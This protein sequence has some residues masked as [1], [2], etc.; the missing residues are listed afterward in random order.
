LEIASSSEG[1]PGGSRLRRADL[2]V[3]VAVAALA[4]VLCLWSV[5]AAGG[6]LFS[7]LPEG[8]YP[9][10][11]AGFRAG[12]LYV[13]LDPPAELQALADP[14]DPTANAPYRAH[15]M[16]YYHGRYFLY[17]GVTPVVLFFWP[18]AAATGWYPTDSCAAVAFSF[19]SVVAG[20]ALLLAVRRRHFP[21]APLWLLAL[22]AS[23][24]ALESSILTLTARA[25]FYQVPIAAAAALGLL[26][27]GAIFRALHS[28][29]RGAAWLAAASLLLGLSVGARPTYLPSGLALVVAGAWLIGPESRWRPRLQLALAALLPALACGLGIAAYNWLRFGSITEF[30]MRYQLAGTNQLHLAAFFDL[31]RLGA[32][33][34]QYLL[35]P[36]QWQRY[37][38]FFVPATGA[39]YGLLRYVPWAWLMVAAFFSGRASQGGES[40]GRRPLVAAV[41]AGLAANFFLLLLFVGVNDRYMADY[42][43]AC[44]LLAG[45]GAYALW[46]AL[47]RRPAWR[48]PGGV[49]LSGCA[50]FS[51]FTS[52][53]AVAAVEPE[54]AVPLAIARMGDEPAALAERAA[55]VRYGPLRLDLVM[56]AG[57]EG[58]AEPLLRTGS[59]PDRRDWIQLR[60]LAPGT[61]QI[62]LY[63]TGLGLLEGDPFPVPPDRR[64][65]VEA[66]LGSLLPPYAHPVFTRWTREQYEDRRR[67]VRISVNGQE[68]LRAALDCYPSS[69]GD[70]RLL[71]GDALG[72]GLE[73]AFSGRIISSERLALAPPEAR[74]G[75]GLTRGP[76]E[77]EVIFPVA[78]TAAAEPL[79][80]S[81]SGGHSDLL[82]FVS[83]GGGRLHFIVDHFGDRVLAGPS[84]ALDPLRPHRLAIWLGS[85]AG[86]G[87]SAGS[88]AEP[89]PR[90]A[91]VM[92]DGAIALDETWRFYPAAPDSIQLG[93]NPFGATTA[94]A[95]FTGEILAARSLADFRGLPEA[96]LVS[97]SGAVR[98]RVIFPPH[99]SGTAEP[100]VVTGRSGAGDLLYVNYLDASHVSFGFDHWGSGGVTGPSTPVDF[101]QP[102]LLE[103]S[104]DSLYPANHPDRLQRGQVRVVLDGVTVLAGNSPCFPALPSELSI[105]RNPLGGSTAGPAFTGRMLSLQ[106]EPSRPPMAKP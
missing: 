80:V 23:C 44:L 75:V 22:A 84:L 74:P 65:R 96:R 98:L 63:H 1:R 72:H 60:Y 100:L 91:V 35:S 77:M 81:G 86:P 59:S 58:R 71:G 14:Y 3:V 17:F 76:I 5:V 20:L 83:E 55:G 87:T 101:R 28:E 73:E 102:H 29:R 85:F 94:L 46:G 41:A 8:Y 16:S 56:A 78:P 19:L 37:F 45:F 47:E 40:R 69:P 68:V 7:R 52:L 30:G 62:G 67:D 21:R 24:L 95:R 53:G 43:P 104:M 48:L 97:G 93:T 6:S 31:R 13:P 10:L 34:F 39:P 103:L 25:N 92:A 50:V 38:P 15:D 27:Y 12:H 82:A 88:A 42:E 2:A 66:S 99:A 79:V 57:K 106:R 90:R 32:N 89:W 11:T 18:I 36:A 26:M 105:G 54:G 33:G 49:L 61:A 9:L 64:L 4:A 51:I 70:L